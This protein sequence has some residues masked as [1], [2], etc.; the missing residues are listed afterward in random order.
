MN[1]T[2]RIGDKAVAKVSHVTITD[3]ERPTLVEWVQPLFTLT[4]ALT[5][6][7]PIELVRA[8]TADPLP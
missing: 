8:L 1:A 4:V 3:T 6:Y 5:L 2:I 7:M